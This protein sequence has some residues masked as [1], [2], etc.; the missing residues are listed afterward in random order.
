MPS[1]LNVLLAGLATCLLL[2]VGWFMYRRRGG[3]DAPSKP[4][5]KPKPDPA[6]ASLKPIPGSSLIWMPVS[7]E[8][9][10][11]MGPYAAALLASNLSVGLAK[12][13]DA[14]SESS[15]ITAL[16]GNGWTAQTVDGFVR[17]KGLVA[18]TPGHINGVLLTKMAAPPSNVRIASGDKALYVDGQDVVLGA[19]DGAPL[20]QVPTT[21]KTAAAIFVTQDNRYLASDV[22][23]RNRLVAQTSG[24]YTL[25]VLKPTTGVKYT[26][27]NY[28]LSPLSANEVGELYFSKATPPSDFEI[29]V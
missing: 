10:E 5:S 12:A 7:P 16:L 22:A 14:A 6:S 18:T 17:E 25:I 26:L 11:L 1:T 15:K 28:A 29:K 2:V 20:M 27:W 4:K 3:A 9:P 19:G 23:A 13:T 21:K 8:H 24:H